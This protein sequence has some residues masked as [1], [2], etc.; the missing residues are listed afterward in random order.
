MKLEKK[1]LNYCSEIYEPNTVRQRVSIFNAAEKSEI[2]HGKDIC[3]FNQIEVEDYFKGLNSI[4]TTLETTSSILSKCYEWCINEVS[5][6]RKS[7]F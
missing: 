7:K 6:D 2:R 1:Y 3:E 4:R 5:K